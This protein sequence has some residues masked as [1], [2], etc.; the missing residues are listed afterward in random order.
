MSVDVVIASP[1]WGRNKLCRPDGAGIG[2][3]NRRPG[4]SCWPGA[5]SPRG[6]LIDK[7]GTTSLVQVAD[8]INRFPELLRYAVQR[9]KTLCPMLGKMKI[10]EILTRAGLHLGA[11]RR[12]PD[13]QGEARRAASSGKRFAF[14]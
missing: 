13:A 2:P 14:A 7:K 6:S 5:P 12:R 4:H 8:P 10:A 9:I 1:V 3:W 11:T